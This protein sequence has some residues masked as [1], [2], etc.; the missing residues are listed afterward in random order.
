P[1]LLFLP[2]L[3]LHTFLNK[4]FSSRVMEGTVVQG[5]CDS[6]EA[7]VADGLT[8]AVFLTS[9]CLTITFMALSS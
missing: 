8:G 1:A 9:F 6:K 3:C 2:A 5:R 7:K 4:C